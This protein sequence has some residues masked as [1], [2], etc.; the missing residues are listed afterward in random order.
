M[1]TRTLAGAFRTILLLLSATLSTGCDS[2]ELRTEDF[3]PAFWQDADSASIVLGWV[4]SAED[5]ISCFT[6]AA[7][8]RRLQS[9]YGRSVELVGI[10]VDVEPGYAERYFRSQRV[11][12]AVTHISGAEYKRVFGT[13]GMPAFYLVEHGRIAAIIAA[14]K[15]N[16][17]EL[18]SA[19]G[20]LLSNGVTTSRMPEV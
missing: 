5:C 15:A 20:Q 16:M 18:W 8:F 14:E 17:P 3:A 7:E 12:V 11:S 10:A 2:R 1:G 6:P 9:T 19:L 4:F 13:A